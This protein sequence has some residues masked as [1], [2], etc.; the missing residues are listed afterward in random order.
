MNELCRVASFREDTLSSFIL[1]RDL[2]K[3]AY[4]LD[5]S[6]SLYVSAVKRP[7][8]APDPPLGGPHGEYAPPPHRNLEVP[9]LRVSHH[10]SSRR[11]EEERVAATKDRIA[12]FADTVR[13]LAYFWSPN[14]RYLLYL[15]LDYSSF[16]YNLRCGVVSLSLSPPPRGVRVRDAVL[17]AAVLSARWCCWDSAAGSTLSFPNGKFAASEHFLR[18]YVSF[19][20]QYAQVLTL[21]SPDSDAYPRPTHPVPPSCGRVASPSWVR[22]QVRVLW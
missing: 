15:V 22:L 8:C 1:S 11:H 21:F 14:G 2:Q 13:L 18:N 3:V 19:F 16:G 6:G 10:G 20:D 17:I 5:N 9:F 7:S 4:A 12:E